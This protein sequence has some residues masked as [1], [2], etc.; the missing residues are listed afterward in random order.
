MANLAQQ[1]LMLHFFQMLVLA[2]F[3]P[4]SD[5][6]PGYIDFIGVGCSLSET[7]YQEI[8]K[9]MSNG[10]KPASYSNIFILYIWLVHLTF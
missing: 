9:T 4:T 1:M 5:V 7:I 2:T 6:S 10:H 8:N 3:F